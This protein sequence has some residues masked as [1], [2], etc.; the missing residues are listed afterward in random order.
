MKNGTISNNIFKDVNLNNIIYKNRESL[1]NGYL[2]DPDNIYYRE[3]VLEELKD[4]LMPALRGE[5]PDNVLIDGNHGTG[6][7]L[8]TRIV[9]ENLENLTKSDV[10]TD[11]YTL[12]VNCSQTGT[13][14]SIVKTLISD[15][16][17]KGNVSSQTLVN[18]YDSYI[19]RF[20]DLVNVLD[21]VVIVVF[22]ELDQI[23]EDTVVND[24]LRSVEN[25]KTYRGICV[26]G[27][28]NDH[29]YSYYLNRKTLDV[30]N[31]V[32]IKFTTYTSNQMKQILSRRAKLA[33]TDEM[34]ENTDLSSVINECCKYT[35]Q[36]RN[37]IRYALDL[38]LE[39]GDLAYRENSDYID[40]DFVS[41]AK[42]ILDNKNIKKVLIQLPRTDKM[43]L[44]SLSYLSFVYPKICEQL[45][46]RGKD[47]ERFD[48]IRS[49]DVYNIYEKVCR[50]NEIE[51]VGDHRKWESIR[52]LSE[53]DVIDT[54]KTSLGRNQG[55]DT[56]LKP[57]MSYKFIMNT[58]GDDDDLCLDVIKYFKY[59]DGSLRT[60]IIHGIDN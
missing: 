32:K 34:I 16:E 46:R 18:S 17:K 54:I 28:T 42:E 37:S 1:K 27:I 29:R 47:T 5:T 36:D 2:L 10:Y 35:L 38:L 50:D 15:L 53:L 40:S 12:H 51:P 44:L 9:M 8:L 55:V 3:D 43:I 25:M 52:H 33:F 48:R 11:V 4:S 22:D 56:V 13:K 39:V 57:T 41:E 60:F 21:G 20:F 19:E 14:F 30:F 7:T 6:K 59:N 24:I 31:P 26:V 45:E 49:R 23:Q 58:L